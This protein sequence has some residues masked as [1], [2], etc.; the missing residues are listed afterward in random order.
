M[1][2]R[3]GIGRSSTKPCKLV[4]LQKLCKWA[5]IIVVNPK[6]DW[7]LWRMCTP[8]RQRPDIRALDPEIYL[9]SRTRLRINRIWWRVLKPRVCITGQP[10]ETRLNHLIKL[11]LPKLTWKWLINWHQRSLSSKRLP[12]WTVPRDEISSTKCL[13]RAVHLSKLRIKQVPR[14]LIRVRMDQKAEGSRPLSSTKQPMCRTRT[15]LGSTRKLSMK[16]VC[17]WLRIL[18]ASSHPWCLMS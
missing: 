10:P 11:S 2:T 12:K 9:N 16:R 6:I 7:T 15:I 18:R 1:P 17:S 3:Q 4:V 13:S 5:L 8:W 14:V